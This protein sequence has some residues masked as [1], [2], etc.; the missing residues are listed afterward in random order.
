MSIHIGILRVVF[1]ADPLVIY[2]ILVAI[3]MIHTERNKQTNKQVNTNQSTGFNKNLVVESNEMLQVF[4]SWKVKGD[5]P[6]A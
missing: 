6:L 2:D 1:T 3:R 5:F 4:A